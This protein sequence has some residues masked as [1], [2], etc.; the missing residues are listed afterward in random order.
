M[1]EV[2]EDEIKER[3]P[4]LGDIGIHLTVKYFK[5]TAQ[6]IELGLIAEQE[7]NEIEGTYTEKECSLSCLVHKT[8]EVLTILKTIVSVIQVP[9]E[10]LEFEEWVQYSVDYPKVICHDGLVDVFISSSNAL[11]KN[12]L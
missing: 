6:A 4:A 3:Y 7:L 1:A 2:T 12:N 5:L 11:N 10:K 9:R 8:A